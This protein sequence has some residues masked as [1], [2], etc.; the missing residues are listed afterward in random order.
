MAYI[1]KI[2]N[3]ETNATYVGQT[4][5]T[6]EHRFNKH[7]H[8]SRYHDTFLYRAMRKYGFD[9]FAITLIEEVA[10]DIRYERE[11]FWIR[12]LNSLVPNGY[13]L[14]IGGGGGD[15][16]ASPNYRCGIARRNTS[17]ENNSMYGKRGE[18]NPNYGS[19]RTPE[20][21]D[22][23]TKGVQRAWDS[24][25]G[26]RRKQ[27][28]SERR[29]GENNSMYGRTPPNA[30]KVVFDGKMYDS[31]AEASRQTGITPHFIKKN[32]TIINET[33]QT[34]ACIVV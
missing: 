16:S 13:N 3:T 8:A 19:L 18:N 33:S 32:G 25:S 12:E 5:S 31:I 11:I 1:Y 2:T 29:S 6:I 22:R 28:L 4:T 23:L 10:D 15:T 17:G 26:T 9:K 7:K 27:A 21:R 34:Q 14:T 30:V 24:P 20:Q